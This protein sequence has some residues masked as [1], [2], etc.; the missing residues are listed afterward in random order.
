MDQLLQNAL[1]IALLALCL[2]GV[3]FNRSL[4]LDAYA[5]VHVNDESF[6]MLSGFSRAKRRYIHVD[7]AIL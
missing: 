3:F 4:E 5:T 7:V 6:D 2:I 1:V